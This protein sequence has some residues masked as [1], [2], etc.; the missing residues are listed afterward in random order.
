MSKRKDRVRVQALFENVVRVSTAENDRED[1]FE[2]GAA[3]HDGTPIAEEVLAASQD[4]AAL[5]A[6]PGVR[7]PLTRLKKFRFQLLEEWIVA[8]VTPCRVADIVGGKGL[9]A[10][11]LNQR[12]YQATTIDPIPQALP[13][14]Y[15]DLAADRQIRIAPT[16]TVARHDA[17]FAPEMAQDFDLLLAMHAHGCN[18]QI[19]DAAK[20]Y[21]RDFLLLPCCIIDEPLRPAPGVH[22]LQCVA[23][24]AK[25]QGFALEPFR[26]NFKGQNIGLYARYRD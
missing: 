14:K 21:G 4:F 2:E 10:Y 1:D 5:A 25:S 3:R 15:K 24:Y 9:I 18:I 19:I 11:L 12:G 22:W 16:E 17:P 6:R 20:R 23:D 13:T 7:R 8:N 26:L